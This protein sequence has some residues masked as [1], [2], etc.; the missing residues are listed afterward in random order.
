MNG[1]RLPVPSEPEYIRSLGRDALPRTYHKED[2][3]KLM[4]AA[5]CASA[6]IPIKSLRSQYP[7]AMYN[8]K[9]GGMAR[10]QAGVRTPPVRVWHLAD[11]PAA[12]A[13]RAVV[14]ENLPAHRLLGPVQAGLSGILPMGPDVLTTFVLSYAR[15]LN[16][17]NPLTRATATCAPSGG[18][19]RKC[20]VYS[21][22]DGL[23]LPPH[24]P[25]SFPSVYLA[26]G[27]PGLGCPGEP[28]RG[29]IQTPRGYGEHRQRGR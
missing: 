22:V 18:L 27:N 19:P 29:G 5:R 3:W 24:G 8:P 28:F 14:G 17:P 4:T 25:R 23:R 7:P 21:G 1:V 15:Q 12:S 2:F 13:L 9:A 26:H 16:H 20:R 10:F 11:L 6:V